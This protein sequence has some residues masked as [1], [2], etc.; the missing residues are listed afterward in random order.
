M[1]YKINE[2]FRHKGR[3]YKCVSADGL[4]RGVACNKCALKDE[5]TTTFLDIECTKYDRLDSQEVYYVRIPDKD[6]SYSPKTM[7]YYIDRITKTIPENGWISIHPS[8]TKQGVMVM[9]VQ[10]NSNINLILYFRKGRCTAFRNPVTDT[11]FDATKVYIKFFG[12]VAC[13]YND[14]GKIE[15]IPLW[16]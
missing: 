8:F 5:C 9:E 12:D 13:V 10:Y 11:T 14:V 2:E 7:N 16:H 1:F 6:I 15:S 3:D 4:K